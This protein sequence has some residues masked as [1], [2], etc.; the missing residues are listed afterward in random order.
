MVK[1]FDSNTL[2]LYLIMTDTD[3]VRLHVITTNAH[4]RVI[5]SE[6]NEAVFFLECSKTK[7]RKMKTKTRKMNT[8]NLQVKNKYERF[9]EWARFMSFNN[10]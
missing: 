9:Q 10:E 5:S 1:A 3:R 6:Q 7:T 2:D 4:T 8:K